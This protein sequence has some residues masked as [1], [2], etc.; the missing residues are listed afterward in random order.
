MALTNPYDLIV[1]DL[2]LP[3]L[4]GLELLRRLR[5]AGRRTPVLVLTARDT[6]EDI[7]REIWHVEPCPIAPS[8]PPDA[9]GPAGA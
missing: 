3:G 7:V 6:A 1:L 8:P 9:A 5:A 4:G 2:M